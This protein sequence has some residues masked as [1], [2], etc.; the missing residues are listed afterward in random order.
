MLF[1]QKHN[2]SVHLNVFKERGDPYI[3]CHC[4][5]QQK[6]QDIVVEGER[7]GT[8]GLSFC[9]IE[10]WNIFFGA[11]GYGIYQHCLPGNLYFMKGGHYIYLYLS[12]GLV[13]QISSEW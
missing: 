13:D 12:K 6:V 2:H 8:E 7:K 3:L 9:Y 5:N 1:V 10:V 11:N 4:I